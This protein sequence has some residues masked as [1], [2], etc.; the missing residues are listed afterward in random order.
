MGLPILL[1]FLWA[2]E[3]SMR[4][5]SGAFIPTSKF[6]FAASSSRGGV[7][8]AIQRTTGISLRHVGGNHIPLSKPCV[9]RDELPEWTNPPDPWLPAVSTDTVVP[10]D[11]VV[12]F[13]W[14]FVVFLHLVLW[15][16]LVA[17]RWRRTVKLA[18]RSELGRPPV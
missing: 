4:W 18:S 12:I 16:G 13:A 15:G 9:Y 17:W 8:Y 14:W 3:D 6:E 10:G 11:T 2:W 1:F 5:G 7:G